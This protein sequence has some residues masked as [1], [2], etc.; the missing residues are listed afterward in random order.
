M[1]ASIQMG[2][3]LDRQKVKTINFGPDRCF[4]WKGGC[5]VLR[6]FHRAAKSLNR[7]ASFVFV[8]IAAFPLAA[9]ATPKTKKAACDAP[10]YFGACDPYVPG[11]IGNPI[12]KKGFIVYTTWPGGPAE[13]AGICAGDLIVGFNGIS[14]S[15]LDSDQILRQMVSSSPGPMTLTVQRGNEKKQF[16]LDRAK[17][18]TLISLSKQKYMT[19]KGFNSGL[20][21][22]PED[23]SH[24]EIKV[25]E[26]YEK[27][28]AGHYGYKVVEG[29]FPVPKATRKN[30]IRKVR[31][32]WSEE[33]RSKVAMGGQLGGFKYSTGADFMVLKDPL[34]MFITIVEPN[35]PALHAGLL[36]GDQVLEI[37]GE[38]L[39]SLGTSRMRALFKKL[40]GP[41]LIVLNIKQGN[42]EKSVKVMPEA[43]KMAAQ[44]NPLWPLPYY[45]SRPPGN[46]YF[47]GAQVLFD[48]TDGRAM[49]S[50]VDY[51]SSAFDVGLRPGDLVLS[52][53]STPIQQLTRAQI[54]SL[55][56]PADSSPIDFRVSRMHKRLTFKITPATRAE[57]QAKIGRKMTKH[58]PSAEGCPG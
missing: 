30:A 9:V 50:H 54:S 47:V 53:N 44:S 11:T 52:I 2:V 13:K 41:H 33:G 22:V 55:L 32:L 46:G 18:T 38:A 42:S 20:T 6:A 1:L 36:P 21:M 16:K 10:S 7:V 23:E 43:S 35:S 15:T 34:Q 31:E 4:L 29:V 39:P 51:P 27:R 24:N 56:A 5:P 48:S 19:F 57:E 25:L 12:S 8:F 28:L 26:A 40:E 49:I 14:A 3:C 37:N 58:G 45:S 17:E